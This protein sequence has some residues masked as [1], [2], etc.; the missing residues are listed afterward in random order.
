MAFGR[1]AT[2]GVTAEVSEVE[3]ATTAFVIACVG[4]CIG[5]GI[6][7]EARELYLAKGIVVEASKAWLGSNAGF[8]SE[9]KAKGWLWL[10]VCV[11]VGVLV[12]RLRT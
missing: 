1:F 12:G 4:E 6:G 3:G 10:N 7:A 11:L 8:G 5:I 9:T 2:I